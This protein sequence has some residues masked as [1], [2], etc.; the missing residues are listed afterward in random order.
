MEKVKGYSNKDIVDKVASVIDCNDFNFKMMHYDRERHVFNLK[1]H[2]I[3]TTK[4]GA[5]KFGFSET[6]VH[7]DEN[8]R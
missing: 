3:Y 8:R 7:L 6:I 4:G 5:E 1:M 2:D